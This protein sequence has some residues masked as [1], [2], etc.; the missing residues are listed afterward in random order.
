[1]VGNYFKTELVGKP[2]FDSTVSDSVTLV[3]RVLLWK[4]D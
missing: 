4:L 3:E 1:M 2:N